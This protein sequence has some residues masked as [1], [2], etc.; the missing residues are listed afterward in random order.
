MRAES[1]EHVE[2]FCKRANLPEVIALALLPLILWAFRRLIVIGGRRYFAAAVLSYA[3][4]LLTHNISSLI[5]TPLLLAYL[6]VLR[7]AYS[8][9]STTRTTQYAIRP[10]PL[11]P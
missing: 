10:P 6:I 5:F 11:F 7:V 9:S 8:V 1:D 3:A 2:C 4:L